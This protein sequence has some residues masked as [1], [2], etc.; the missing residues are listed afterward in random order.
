M[1]KI[2]IIMVIMLVPVLFIQAC[3]K[4]KSNNSTTPLKEEQGMKTPAET[5]N[6][7]FE[8]LKK[9]DTK[10]FNQYVQH[11][12]GKDRHQMG[13]QLF[14]TSL[15]KEGEEFLGAI[16]E[17]LEYEILSEET[18]GDQAYVFIKISNKNLSSVMKDLITAAMN[19]RREKKESKLNELIRQKN[20]NNKQVTECKTE[21]VKKAD[22]WKIIMD[23]KIMNAICGGL[24]SGDFEIDD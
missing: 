9:L 20:K 8:A 13:S 7:A 23:D 6:L 16:V 24:F 5:D 4:Q 19:E 17:N 12:A 10:L 2:V 3:T 14:D 22:E 21:L 18:N 15:D 1:K 11:T